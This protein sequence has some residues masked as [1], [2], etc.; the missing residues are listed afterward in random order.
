MLAPPDLFQL[1]DEAGAFPIGLFEEPA[2]SESK[3]ARA[4]IRHAP[5]KGGYLRQPLLRR[6]PPRREA[7]NQIGNRGV[8]A[9]VAE[10][11]QCRPAPICRRGQLRDQP[12]LAGPIRVFHPRRRRAGISGGG[13]S[14]T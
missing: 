11:L 14:Q 7:P 13:Q 2:K 10:A 4:V 12:L 1:F 6:D 8:S 3:A 9:P 5:H